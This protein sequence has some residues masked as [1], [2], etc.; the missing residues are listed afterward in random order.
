MKCT[1]YRITLLGVSVA[2]AMVLSYIETLIPLSI[3]VPGVKMGLANLVMVFLLYKLDWKHAAAVSII[4]V[5]L[6]ALLF[7]NAAS[8]A[9]SA[10]GAALS[11]IVMS[12]LKG[13][14]AFSSVGVSMAGAVSHNAGQII[15]AVLLTG[16]RE[17]AW[18]LPPLILSGIVT[19]LAIGAVGAVLI[20]KIKLK[21][22]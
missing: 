7:G 6:T 3:A 1:A 2:A 19:G 14:G 11:L 15:M 17:I 9:Y 16:T 20:S 22:D 4:R 13:S 10:S 8:L 21:T 5:L 12:L 18:W